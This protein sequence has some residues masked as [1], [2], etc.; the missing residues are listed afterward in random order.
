MPTPAP[1]TRA[2]LRAPPT[3]RV[4]TRWSTDDI[5]VALALTGGGDLQRAADLCWALLGDGRVRAALETRVMGLLRLPL[6][7][8]ESGD[9]RTSGRVVRALEGGD[10]YDAHSEAALFSLAA[11]GILLGVGLAQRVWKIAPSGRWIG[12]LK[13]YNARNLRWD[14]QRRMWVVRTTQGDVDIVPGDRR[15]VLY[16]PSCA[17]TPD[18]DELPWMWGAWRACAKPWLGKDFSWGD[19]QH[20]AEVHG[21]PIRTADVSGDKPPSKKDRDELA[22]DLA[23]I[24]A[25]TAIVPGPGMSPKLLEA[26]AKTWQMF[27]AAIDTAAREIAIAITG[28]S[29]S[30]EIVQGQDTG[31]TL[32]GRVRQD[33]I[34]GTAQTLSTCLHDQA[35]T[36][37]AVINFSADDLAAWPRWKTDPPQDAAARGEAMSKLGA[38]IEAADRA[39]PEGKRVDR[40]AVFEAANIPLEDIPAN[41]AS[42]ASVAPTVPPAPP[43]T[44]AA[45]A[46][47]ETP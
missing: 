28:Q 24:G 11:W 6:T 21:S 43:A 1:S 40:R 29:S 7:W 37:Y 4:F 39:A 20:H 27:P 10:W 5:E 22:E 17:G 36:D 23:N 44:P 3:S 47:P 33:L 41:A 45:G 13:P 46:A 35:L 25:N 8:D 18:G 34:E 16:A 9:R 30:T 26:V 2:I 42:A 19:W 38:G 32:H 15:W 31:A 14:T 12:V